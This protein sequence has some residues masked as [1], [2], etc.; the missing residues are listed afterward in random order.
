MSIP[1]ASQCIY[2]KLLEAT[3]WPRNARPLRW[4]HASLY[5]SFSPWDT[6]LVPLCPFSSHGVGDRCFKTPGFAVEPVRGASGGGGLVSGKVDLW[7]V[8]YCG[9]LTPRAP[10]SSNCWHGSCKSF[11]IKRLCLK[12][13]HLASLKHSLDSSREHS[14]KRRPLVTCGARVTSPAPPREA[15]GG[16]MR[17]EPILQRSHR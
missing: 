10:F 17:A 7:Q 9:M 16:V 5:A 14:R 3:S 11:R 1:G 6:G 15:G 2:F 12:P 8:L 4:V 13:C